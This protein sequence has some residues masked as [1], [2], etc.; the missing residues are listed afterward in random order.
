MFAVFLL[1]I[2]PAVGSLTVLFP[3]TPEGENP[4]RFNA[5][6]MDL[7]PDAFALVGRVVRAIP[8]DACD[9]LD[10]ANEVAGNIALIESA[11]NCYPKRKMEAAQA[12]G[13]SGAVL[14][15]V[16]RR[17]GINLY[18]WDFGSTDHVVIPGVDINPDDAEKLVELLNDNDNNNV[19]VTVEMIGG[20]STNPWT[21][22][23]ENGVWVTKQL[24]M[25]IIGAT[26]I[27]LALFKMYLFYEA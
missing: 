16:V 24:F 10:N 2:R 19:N 21:D 12:A 17:E 13:A 27:L 1:A 22:P 3:I 20:D 7:G 6:T 26:T 23:L 11:W 15:S 18:Y 4:V 8:D 25:L 9:D 14:V 5:P